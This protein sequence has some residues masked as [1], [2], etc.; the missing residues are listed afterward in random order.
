MTSEEFRRKMNLPPPGSHD[1]KARTTLPRSKPQHAQALA[2]SPPREV[3][4]KHGAGP[5]IVVSITGHRVRLLDADNFAGG[6][7]ALVDQLRY[8]GLIPNDD[9]ETITLQTE[10]VRVAHYHQEHTAIELSILS[11]QEAF[12]RVR[13]E[14]N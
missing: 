13:E 5:R 11:A 12:E 3:Q 6:S 2:G 9:P 14:A 7:K 10:Q 8:S 4:S 1:H